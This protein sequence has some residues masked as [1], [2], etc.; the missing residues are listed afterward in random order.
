MLYPNANEHG[1]YNSLMIP[2][3]KVDDVT[4]IVSD[5]P[6]PDVPKSHMSKKHYKTHYSHILRWIISCFVETK[7][8][9]IWLTFN[10]IQIFSIPL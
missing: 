6:D 5:M 10:L 3:Q 9:V 7:H 1:I 4:F 8:W 2:S